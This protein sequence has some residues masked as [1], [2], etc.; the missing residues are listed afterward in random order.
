MVHMMA[1]SVRQATRKRAGAN[2]MSLKQSIDNLQAAFDAVA[3][4]IEAAYPNVW[5][6]TLDMY[7][8][9]ETK[10]VDTDAAVNFLTRENYAG[11]GGMPLIDVAE[12]YGEKAVED[13]IT[14]IEYGVYM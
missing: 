1:I 8:N 13:Y 10:V 6:K 7:T 5:K 11:W 2:L 14:A 12:E 9:D 4:E 3:H